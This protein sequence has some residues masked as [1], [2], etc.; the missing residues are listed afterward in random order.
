MVDYLFPHFL[1]DPR[2]Y[3]QAESLWRERWEDLLR[4]VGQE[5]LWQAPWANTSFVNGTSM[6]DG[7]PIF[8]AI[9]SQRKLAI[10]VIQLEPLENPHEFSVWADTFAE[11]SPEVVKELVVCCVLTLESLDEAVERMRQ[12]IT[13]E[14][15]Q[16][17]PQ[18]PDGPCPANPSET[19][20]TPASDD[21]LGRN[22]C[23]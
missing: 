2:E 5:R 1:S 22:V 6:Q 23:P 19:L 10:C 21:K 4:R 20:L 15:I 9:C 3:E 18:P 7:N 17:S 12:W 8:S 16:Q 13:E 11:G 14:K